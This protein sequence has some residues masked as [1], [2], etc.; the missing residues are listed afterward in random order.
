MQISTIKKELQAFV[1]ILDMLAET[2]GE[3]VEFVLHDL[4][5]P[6]SSV[7]YALNTHITGRKIG[8]SFNYLIDRVLLS[9]RFNGKYLSNYKFK[10]KD[11]KT[12]RSSSVF[13]RD[14]NDEIIGSICINMDITKIS[15]FKN[16]LEQLMFFPDDAKE[17]KNDEFLHIDNIVDEI[18]DTIIAKNF[19]TIEPSRQ[20][21]IDIIHKLD[22]QGLFLAKNAIEKVALKMN[23]SKVTVYSYLDEIKK[24]KTNE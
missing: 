18:I 15:Q 8:Q 4:T 3:D 12:I 20:E 14:S 19:T 5:Q 10:S 2:L 1:P 16:F 21:K 11:G 7:V 23:L 6:Q 24:N 22:E 9:P 13:I 17:E